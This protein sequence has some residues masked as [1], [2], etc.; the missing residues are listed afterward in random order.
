MKKIQYYL[1]AL[2]L[3]GCIGLWGCS[4]D[5]SDFEGSD[6][7]FVAFSL[8][9]G[10][11]SYPALIE[12]GIIRVEVPLGTD[13]TE[14]EVEYSLS[15]NA[16]VSP[17]PSTISDWYSDQLFRVEAYNGSF[18]S[19][20]YQL[21]ELD[22]SLQ[23]DVVLDTQAKLDAFAQSGVNRILGNLIIGANSTDEA[24]QIYHLNGLNDLKEVSFNLV[25]HK[26]YQGDQL[27]GLSKLEKAGGIYIGSQAE[28]EVFG[29][30]KER[31]LAV[32]LPQLQELGN[33][34]VRSNNV[35]QLAL[36]ELEEVGS[37]YIQSQYL[38]ELDLNRLHSCHGDLSLNG[39]QVTSDG[40][41]GNPLNEDSA[42]SSLLSIAFP[43]LQRVEGDFNLV[44][45]WQTN[46]L[47]LPKL[48]H[49]GGRL[50]FNTL[51]NIAKIELP[52]LVAVSKELQLK[53]NDA[54]SKLALP[55]LQQAYSIHIASLNAWSINLKELALPALQTVEQDFVLQ[56]A[57]TEAFELPALQKVGGK[58]EFIEM[59]FIEHLAL[60]QLQAAGQLVLRSLNLLED[61]QLKELRALEELNFTELNSLS[62]L[63]LSQLQQI[64][65]MSLLT[66]QQLEELKL[67]AQLEGE[68]SLTALQALQTLDLSAIP[69]LSKL[70]IN[71]CRSLSLLQGPAQISEEFKLNNLGEQALKLRG[72]QQAKKYAISMGSARALQIEDLKTVAS[73]SLHGLKELHT[74]VVSE[75][76]Q[77][78]NLSLSDCYVL[79]D[80]DFPKLTQ[81]Q[82]KLSFK[83]AGWVGQ[84]QNSLSTHLNG[85]A[86][87]KKAGSVEV[88]NA[89]NLV[90][91]TG[92]KQV[93]PSLE[94]ANWQVKDNKYNPSYEDMLAGKYTQNPEKP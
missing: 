20:V 42:N 74:L 84:A 38:E 69:Q 68:L 44:Y 21:R 72:T 73:L 91:F 49:V 53:G 70:S 50:S 87:L 33:L 85:F 7:Y 18:Q 64:E 75:L 67:P 24:H 40:S 41:Y 8:K 26:S 13:L 15:E 61:L 76:T 30:P 92:L 54:M 71:N 79:Q 56:F 52:A 59:Q 9:L 66:L 93:I 17:D 82:E 57:S 14:A 29:E 43:A 47:K 11:T 36:P 34:V 46:A 10:E 23:K 12:E 32:V 81:V 19:F 2:L 78:T 62:Q 58:L 28:E 63:D 1:S 25:I 5:D 4:D 45:F 51:K 86:Q 65:K 35:R 6:A 48:Q 89:G 60:P 16:Q 94:A 88:L 22:S 80:F 55:A 90:D 77:A 39:S 37:I 3:L 83:G 27:D 31:Q